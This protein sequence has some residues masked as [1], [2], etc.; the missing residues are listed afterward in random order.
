MVV[1]DTEVVD[2]TDQLHDPVD[3][4]FGA[5]LGGGTD[6]NRAVAD[7]RHLITRPSQ[8]IFVFIS[9]LFEGGDQRQL[10]QRGGGAGFR[11]SERLI[12]LLALNDE[13]TP[14]FSEPLAAALAGLGV[15][16]FGCT[17]ELVPR[18]DG[19]RRSSAATS[20]G[21]RNSNSRPLAP[22]VSP[23]GRVNGRDRG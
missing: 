19:R 20:P 10:Q 7:R 15:P 2:L 14:C 17:P 23:R 1:F 3:L 11:R 21:G 18:S 22:P 9:D 8:T 13:G 16:T 12:C 4:F 6:I 5:Q